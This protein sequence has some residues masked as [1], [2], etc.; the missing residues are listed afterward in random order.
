MWK[1]LMA[2]PNAGQKFPLNFTTL[3]EKNPYKESLLGC[4]LFLDC[5]QDFLEL[6]KLI[7]HERVLYWHLNKVQ[8]TLRLLF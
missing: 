7:I 6:S 3:Y 1:F 8:D 2:N 4:S 5:M